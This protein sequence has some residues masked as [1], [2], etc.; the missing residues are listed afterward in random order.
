[1]INEIL[2]RRKHKVTIDVN[3]QA[4]IATEQSLAHLLTLELNIG[5]LGFR[6]SHDLA[7][8]LSKLSPEIID[9]IYDELFF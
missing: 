2:L 3:E 9:N 4:A 8:A 5:S 6:L 1:M 7:V